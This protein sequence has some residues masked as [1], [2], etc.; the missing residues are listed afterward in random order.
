MKHLIWSFCLLWC[1]RSVQGQ[2]LGLGAY[3]P[4]ITT[5]DSLNKGV[6]HELQPPVV[7]GTIALVCPHI[8]LF[9][10]DVAGID[11]LPVT[12]LLLLFYDN[13]LMQI[14]C[15][16]NDAVQQA[17]RRKY[18]SGIL[19]PQKS[20]ALC[21][22]QADKPMLIQQE[23]WTNGDVTARII[24]TEGFTAD[25]RKE[26]TQGIVIVNRRIVSLVSECD[27]PDRYP[28]FERH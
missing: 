25:C 2:V 5:P 18:G 10:A 23:I 19:Q 21:A 12:N 9:K 24:R 17:F 6:F 26:T 1:S 16:S 3:Q 27:L 20:I 11:G 15:D 28:F 4:G 7:K 14:D 8:R 13:K 22:G